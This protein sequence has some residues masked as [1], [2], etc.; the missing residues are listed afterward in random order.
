M[1]KIITM[2]KG[3][4][5]SVVIPAYNE[6]ERIPLTLV[7]IDRHL[8]KAD[9]SYEILVVNDGS[10]DDTAQVVEHFS[11]MIPNL[12]LLDQ[13]KNQGKGKVVNIGMLEARGKYRL[14]MDADNSTSIDHFDKM[15]PYLKD[16]Y[17]VVICSRADKESE[18]SPPQGIL[19]RILGKAG[20]LVIQMLVLPGIWDTQCGFKCFSE[21][22]VEKTFSRQRI[23]G[24]GFDVEILALAKRLGFKI[25]Q[26]PVI[27]V[28]DSASHVGASAYVKTLMETLR[29]RYYL[30]RG[31]Y[32]LK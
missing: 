11:K 6:A 3:P 25:K 15:I 32:N 16:G 17:D 21:G 30:W 28:N 23:F 22:A 18:L 1:A 27:W 13:E 7:D 2:T 26:I 19:R 10:K 4:F 29:I 14:F 8:S 31:V 9:Y 20:N 12:R 24:W 5:L